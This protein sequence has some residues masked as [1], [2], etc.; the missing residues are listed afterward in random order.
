MSCNCNR[1]VLKGD[2][3]DTGPTGPQGPAGTMGYDVYVATMTQSG[4]SDPVVTVL[5][6]T[7]TDT[8]PTWVRTLQG[9]YTLTATASFP[10]VDKLWING[11]A[12][13]FNTGSSVV[14]ICNSSS[15]I[16]GNY[17]LR[18]G[19]ADALVMYVYDLTGTPTDLGT[20]IG[21]TKICLPEIRV[22]P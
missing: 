8:T 6:N 5:E 14:A 12:V 15:V 9:R 3:G 4:T 1:T 11:L 16:S 7:L 17:I 21:T 20:L 13:N 19:S 10:D 18:Y 22:Y 2:K